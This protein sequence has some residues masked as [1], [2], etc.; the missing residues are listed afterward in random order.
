MQ[1]AVEYAVD[2]L[3]GQPDATLHLVTAGG[4]DP[5]A[6]A[7]ILARAEGWVRTHEG[8]EADGLAVETAPLELEAETTQAYAGAIAAYAQDR[9]VEHVLLAPSVDLP[10]EDRVLE[11]LRAGLTGQGLTVDTAPYPRRAFHRGLVGPGSLPKF[12]ALFS[13]AYLFYLLLG[14]FTV[15]NLATGLVVAAVVAG[16][17]HRITFPTPPRLGTAVTCLRAL[18]YAPYLLYEVVKANVEIAAVLLNPRLPIDPGIVRFRSTLESDLARTTLANS[19][20]LT[21]GTLSVD[22]AGDVFYVHRLVSPA[23]TRSLARAVTLVFQ[24]REGLRREFWTPVDG[25]GAA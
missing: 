6:A 24:G 7:T 13:A 18:V 12:A 4:R 14:G 23:S 5:D 25:E 19:I 11:D 2:T 21:P 17:F 3:E 16:L 8:E 22:V 15:F 10:G 9:D 1:D 20:T